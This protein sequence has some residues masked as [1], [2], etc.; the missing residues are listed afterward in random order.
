MLVSR[1]NG[2]M[3]DKVKLS[4]LPLMLCTL[5]LLACVL[6]GCAGSNTS[7]QL[8]LTPLQD[9]YPPADLSSYAC[10]EGYDKDYRFVDMTVAEVVAE[11]KAGASFVLFCGYD[12]CPWC[13]VILN[14]LND[15][16]TERG[17]YAAYI[18]TRKDP[19][20][21]SNVDIDDYDLFVE[22]FGSELKEDDQ[23]IPHLYVPHTFFV[24]DGM[25]INS[26][27]GTVEGQEQPDDP[28]TDEQLADYR[29]FVNDAL[30][31]I[32]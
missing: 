29:D 26:R 28:L 22:A 7:K 16:L 20:W 24:K 8:D 4:F 11:M 32:A 13:N 2:R 15:I 17:I 14:P 19:S 1:Y 25:L 3:T 30:N 23:G 10:A 21:T 5:A 12:N 9:N 6:G 27:Q 18:D 31:Q